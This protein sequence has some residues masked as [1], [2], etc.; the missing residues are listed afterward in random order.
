MRLKLFFAAT[1]TG[2]LTFISFPTDGYPSINLFFLIWVSHIPILWVLRNQGP[3]SCFWWG[4][5]TGTVTNVGGYYWIAYMLETFGG[6]PGWLA[7]IGSVV[8]GAYIG[9]IWGL[10]AWGVNRLTNMTSMTIQWAAPLTMVTLEC[11]FPRVFPA[12][13]GNSQFPFIHLMQIADIVGV[14]GI[15]FLIYWVN[16]VA[17]VFLRALIERRSLPIRLL[18]ITAVI[19]ACVLIYGFLRVNHIDDL[20]AKSPKLRIGVV[21][22]D[23]GVFLVEPPERRR[24]HLR[25]QQRLSAKLAQKGVD[26]IVWSESSYRMGSISR[27]LD[28]LP[29]VTEPLDLPLSQELKLSSTVRRTPQRGFKTPLLFG[30]TTYEKREVL[31]FDGDRPRRVFNSAFLL[32]ETGKIID[33]YDK[34]ELL[35]FGEYV[36]FVDQ[37]PQFYEWVPAA[38]DLERGTEIRSLNMEHKGENVRLGTLICYEGILPEFVREMMKTNPEIL[39]NITNDDWFGPTAERYLH[40][41]LAI[42]RAIEQRR[43][44]VRSTLTGVSG[45]VDPVGRL[46]KLT[47]MTDPEII[48]WDVPRLTVPTLYQ[49]GGYWFERACAGLFVVMLF[50]G[51]WRRRSILR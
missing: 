28:R 23:V 35:V 24:D 22:G 8:H 50:G 1:L 33:R 46:I 4:W 40:F 44:F 26:L 14:A 32:S 31:R 12:A 10:W 6:F 13:M 39:I 16:A 48:H 18:K 5:W 25:I 7:A 2:T 19:L 49:A 34:I 41:A 29:P 36:P 45:F 27:K 11:I 21:E 42:P 38:G 47:K 30:T 43:A 17:F 9:L 37:F 15:T 3:K 20:I 51:Y